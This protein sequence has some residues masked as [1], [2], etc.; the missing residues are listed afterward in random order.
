[1]FRR[2]PLSIV[3]F[4]TVHTAMLYVVK[5]CIQLV[6]RSKCSCSQAGCKPVWHIP[7]LCVQW[8]TSDDGQ[9][10]SPK[11]VEFHSKNKFE[12]LVHLVGFIIGNLTRCMVTWTS[13]LT[14]SNLVLKFIPLICSSLATMM[15]VL[16][17]SG[18]WC[19]AIYNRNKNLGSCNKIVQHSVIL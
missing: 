10:N 11:H 9:R 2:V 1:M 16:A 12:K 15:A 7:L 17:A 6:S 18:Y 8:K 19:R 4:F 5:V 14:E 3:E 13:N